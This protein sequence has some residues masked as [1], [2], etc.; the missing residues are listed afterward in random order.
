MRAWLLALGMIA[1]AALAVV[2]ILRV[3]P[4]P[5]GVGRVVVW[6]DDRP[7][8]QESYDRALAAVAGDRKDGSLRDEDR[9]RVLDRLIDQELLIGRAI[10]LGLH[11]RDPQL[12]NQLATAMIDFLVR[13]AEDD[14]RDATDAELRAFYDQEQFRFERNPQYRVVVEGAALPVP[15]GFLL[16]KEIAQRLGPTAAQGVSELDVGETM[17]LGEGEGAGTVTLVERRSGGAAPFDE[18]REAVN[19]AFLRAQGEAAVRSFL[20]R[21]RSGSDVR[22]EGTQ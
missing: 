7:I 19:A 13:Q 16:E 21:A 3:P 9:E 6:V 2:N 17:A 22:V 12:R 1:G 10:E 4:T 18:A 14:A 20:E 8:S 11:E 5:P 15:S